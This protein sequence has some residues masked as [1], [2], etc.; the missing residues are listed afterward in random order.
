MF[1]VQDREILCY[2]ESLESKD[3]WW[4]GNGWD[5]LGPYLIFNF[6][7]AQHSPSW[8]GPT[9]PFPTFFLSFL[10]PSLPSA[11]LPLLP[12]LS[13]SL[14]PSLL[15]W[16]YSCKANAVPSP[17][18]AVTCLKARKHISLQQTRIAKA[19][20]DCPSAL[21]D[22]RTTGAGDQV[23][24]KISSQWQHKKPQAALKRSSRPY[25]THQNYKDWVH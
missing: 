11:L 12:A 18:L 25:G 19:F 20:I 3:R 13:P 22:N 10:P 7:L 24:C 1:V 21:Q 17:A 16:L 9:S 4:E 2:S 5:I 14:F 15:S 8:T 6:C 23:H